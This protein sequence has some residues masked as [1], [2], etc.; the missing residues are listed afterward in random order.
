MT[1]AFE[2]PLYNNVR[3]ELAPPDNGAAACPAAAGR[4]TDASVHSST[5]DD[6]DAD[7]GGGNRYKV[8]EGAAR[9]GDVRCAGDASAVEG[10][11]D[12][13]LSVRVA[14]VLQSAGR[15]PGAAIAQ[16]VRRILPLPI[17][18]KCPRPTVA[19]MSRSGS[20]LTRVVSSIMRVNFKA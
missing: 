16:A 17:Q 3:E 14:T 20:L 4:T 18:L 2:C 15:E 12:V 8:Y 19:N 9:S 7:T 6:G 1:G 10:D 13:G 11:D 5:V